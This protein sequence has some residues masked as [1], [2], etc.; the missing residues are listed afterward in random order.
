MTRIAV[1]ASARIRV[2]A[3]HGKK[4]PVKIREKRLEA[5]PRSRLTLL[6]IAIPNWFIAADYLILGSAR[7][8]LA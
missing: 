6:N 5:R 2:N 3:A 8:L 1:E 4:Q 7:Y